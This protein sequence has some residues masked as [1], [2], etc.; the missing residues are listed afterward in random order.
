MPNQL[1]RLEKVSHRFR[2]PGG[3][4]RAALENVTLHVAEGETVV[5]AGAGG[6]GKTTLAAVLAGVLLPEE[7][8]V[9]R[10]DALVGTNRQLGVGLV[11][12]NPED[13][14]TS[15][16]VREEMAVVLENLEWEH[17]EITRAVDDML[18]LIGLSERGSSPPSGLS[19]GQKQ[20]LAAASI[21]IAAPRLLLLDEPLSLLDARARRELGALLGDRKESG[22][23]VYFSSDVDDIVRGSRVVVLAEGRIAW[24]GPP[25]EFPLDSPLLSRWG[26]RQPDLTRLATLM[27]PSLTGDAPRIWTPGELAEELCRSR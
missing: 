2:L 23:T 21:L 4:T 27:G 25:E 14:F 19:G 22:A 16:S 24:D 9:T 6:S 8:A 5:V 18:A 17:P 3:A 26:L 15:P 7:G 10:A 13:T 20:L 11:T 1:I 12:Q